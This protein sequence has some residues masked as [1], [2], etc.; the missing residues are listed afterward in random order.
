MRNISFIIIPPLLGY[1]QGN[2]KYLKLDILQDNIEKINKHFKNPDIIVVTG[3]YNS[4]YY[5]IKNGFRICQN[6]LSFDS[7]EIEQVRLG[8]NN[9]INNQI[10]IL[11]EDCQFN[12]ES[13]KKG[14]KKKSEFTIKSDNTNNPGMI[15]NNNL[16]Y[17]I[18]FGL[19]NY[20]GDLLYLNGRLDSVVDFV[21]KPHN[22]NKKIY[23]LAN[24]LT[25]MEPIL[26]L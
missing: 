17:N 21:T 12:C 10:V 7:G 8:I 18:S 16:L 24:H 19:E 11:K 1:K 15:I 13:I 20:F 9:C 6:Q 14:I 26:V 22:I 2:K 23:E 5:K 3:I 25:N 4:E